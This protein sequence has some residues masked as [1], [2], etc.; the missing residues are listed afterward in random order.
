MEAVTQTAQAARRYLS[1]LMSGDDAARKQLVFSPTTAAKSGS[2]EFERTRDT[3]TEAPATHDRHST[4]GVG[5]TATR[6]TAEQASEKTK[7]TTRFAREAQGEAAKRKRASSP[8]SLD[9]AVSEGRQDRRSD[10]GKRPVRIERLGSNPTPI[11]N[12]SL[13]DQRNQP[14]KSILSKG[15]VLRYSGEHLP[16]GKRKRDFGDSNGDE[17]FPDAAA[18]KKRKLTELLKAVGVVPSLGSVTSVYAPSDLNAMGKQSLFTNS[19]SRNVTSG[20]LQL[21][22]AST[23][24]RLTTHSPLHRVGMQRKN[25]NRHTWH[26]T[27]STDESILK[28]ELIDLPPDE[29]TS[30]SA[31]TGIISYATDTSIAPLPGAAIGSFSFSVDTGTTGTTGGENSKPLRRS[32]PKKGKVED[33]DSLLGAALREFNDGKVGGSFLKSDETKDDAAKSSAT[34]PSTLAAFTFGGDSAAGASISSTDAFTFGA[35]TVTKG[36]ALKVGDAAPVSVGGGFTFGAPAATETATVSPAPFS[37]GAPAGASDAAPTTAGAPDPFS[38]GAAVPAAAAAA[39]APA[40]FSFRAASASAPGG[41]APFTFGGAPSASPGMALGAGD[42][43]NG[44]KV[45]RGRRPGRR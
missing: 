38:F 25:M 20:R 9:A 32:K 33:D 15:S 19:I 28:A 40:P 8:K 37:F 7:V 16:G 30:L 2:R 36:D 14:V 35:A 1:V 3:Y 31:S 21:R 5:V 22:G 18:H 6:G 4:Q 12:G 34:G 45:V 26:N 17:S 41:S 13:K 24:G 10:P 43:P 11:P 44:R 42:A 39:G 23:S 29:S 27:P